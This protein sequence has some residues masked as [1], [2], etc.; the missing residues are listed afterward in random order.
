MDTNKIFD[1]EYG[2][3]EATGSTYTKPCHSLVMLVGLVWIIPL[4]RPRIH[5][6][7]SN[8]LHRFTSYHA[9]RLFW[10]KVASIST[11]FTLMLFDQLK[12][13]DVILHSSTAGLSQAT[14]T[15]RKAQ[16]T[17]YIWNMPFVPRSADSFEGVCWLAFWALQFHWLSSV[18]LQSISASQKKDR[19][20]SDDTS[21]TLCLEGFWT[22]CLLNRYSMP[23][24][25]A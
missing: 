3:H 21:T 11:P 22:G 18:L 20:P 15:G 25:V 12:A 5:A 19:L 1:D 9:S 4:F 8:N 13:H 7:V 23:K 6:C 14:D 17:D 16:D 24:L 2:L 10:F